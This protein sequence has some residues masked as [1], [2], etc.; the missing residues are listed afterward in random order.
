MTSC[1]RR[2]REGFWEIWEKSVSWI[3]PWGRKVDFRSLAEAL[4][5]V[6]HVVWGRWK[7]QY[8]KMVSLSPYVEKPFNLKV[9]KSFISELRSRKCFSCFGIPM[10]YVYM[11]WTFYVHFTHRHI[12]TMVHL[13]L[14]LSSLIYTLVYLY[15][16]NSVISYII[17]LNL[18]FD[19]CWS[20]FIS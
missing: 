6:S 7:S 9:I 1:T 13:Y 16:Y 12:M 8:R 10:F 5:Q 17:Y 14:L 19:P 4:W 2:V 11:L 15:F 3:L 20:L 18:L